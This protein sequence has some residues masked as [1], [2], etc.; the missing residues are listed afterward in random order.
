MASLLFLAAFE[1][2]FVQNDWFTQYSVPLLI[3]VI[4]DVCHFTLNDFST[5]YR[6]GHSPA[7]Y[8]L[9]CRESGHSVTISILRCID[10]LG[11]YQACQIH[12]IKTHVL[13]NFQCYLFSLFLLFFSIRLFLFHYRKLYRR[14]PP[15]S[16]NKPTLRLLLKVR[17]VIRMQPIQV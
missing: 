4:N 9:A 6:W 12:D 17:F 15:H 11:A 5:S 13:P 8:K 14:T 10:L 2:Y 1:V 3:S 7:N 16:Q